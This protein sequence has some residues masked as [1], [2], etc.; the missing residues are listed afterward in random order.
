MKTKVIKYLLFGFIV[1]L[2]VCN[3]VIVPIA[4]EEDTMI[5]KA[6]TYRF[7][8]V[9]NAPNTNILQE[10]AFT[11]R[12]VVEE[13]GID[14]LMTFSSMYVPSDASTF[15]LDGYCISVDPIFDLG[16]YEMS[17]DMDFTFY[18]GGWEL[19]S[20]KSITFSE[21]TAVDDAFG[22]WYIANTNYNEVNG[23]S[24]CPTLQELIQDYN[25]TWAEFQGMMST[26]STLYED[27]LEQKRTAYNDGID[28]GQQDIINSINA[29]ND[30]LSLMDTFLNY[31]MNNT[32]S[33]IENQ[34]DTVYQNGIA[35]GNE[36]GF[37][38]GY[39]R[40]YNRGTSEV[41]GENLL[42]ETFN[43]P[44]NAL[45]QWVLFE[46]PGGI[47]VTMGG[48]F[49]AVIALAVLIIFLKMFAGG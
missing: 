38:D 12:F 5:L 29:D 6:G 19:N 42:G 11:S 30:F 25:G 10:I 47:E 34:M 22:N 35:R 1:C 18:N 46:T 17:G 21:D 40:G 43:A 15:F 8:D 45:N 36:D 37:N 7:N 44:L 26:N 23:G 33:V 13:M 32:R 14:S 48:L 27:F 9:L 31:G 24:T 2:F 16:G 3:L 49:T 39:N 20:V 28:F 4:A 41:F